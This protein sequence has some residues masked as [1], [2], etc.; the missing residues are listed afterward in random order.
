MIPRLDGP[1]AV[2]LALAISTMTTLY[3]YTAWAMPHIIRL[4]VH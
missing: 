4:I 3:G 1:Q 2:Y